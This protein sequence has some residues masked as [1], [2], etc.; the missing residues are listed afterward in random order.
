MRIYTRSSLSSSGLYGTRVIV[1]STIEV[2]DEHRGNGLFTAL[3]D[4][5]L[6]ESERF[7]ATHLVVESVANP[8][9]QAYLR[10]Q[11]FSPVAAA[12]TSCPSV[13]RPL[14]QQPRPRTMAP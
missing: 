11:G 4:R 3:L 8:R 2:H 12:D 14:S 6:R 9:F 7:A 1:L 5:L 10:R 13:A